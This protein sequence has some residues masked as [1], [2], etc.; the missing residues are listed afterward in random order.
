MPDAFGDRAVFSVVLPVT[1]VVVKPDMADLRPRGVTNQTFRFPFPGLPDTVEAL[2]E[3]MGP[4][5]DTVKA[6]EPDRVVVACTPEHMADGLAAAAQLRRFVEDRTGL[7]VTM[8]SDAVT[9]ALRS[10]DVQ[11]IG[12]VTPFLATANAN[13][14]AHFAAH[15]ITVA[16]EAGFASA[17]R[18][19][20]IPLAS[21]RRRSATRSL[22]SIRPMSTHLC[23]SARPWS[24]RGSSP[25]WRC[26]TT[27]RFSRSTLRRTGW[28]CASTASKIVSTAM[29]CSSRA[30]ELP[31]TG[32]I[33]ARCGVD[34]DERTQNEPN[35]T[36]QG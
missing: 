26:A 35:P 32:A 12:L 22:A 14:E 13:V 34:N 29:A 4:T 20:R 1:N 23:R 19:G 3:L 11:R 33:D 25:P 5:L 27:S 28:H 36:A 6:C 9:A 8:A 24:V 31:R 2:M 16:S 30:T 7:A 18:V 21:A 15:G 17:H 10:L